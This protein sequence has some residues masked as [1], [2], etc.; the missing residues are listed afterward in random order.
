MIDSIIHILLG[1]SLIF[2]GIGGTYQ[3]KATNL[4]F[5]SHKKLE[6]KV[7]EIEKITDIIKDKLKYTEGHYGKD[8]WGS[9]E[10][11][12]PVLERWDQLLELLKVELKDAEPQ[13]L[14]KKK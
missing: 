13:H 7:F 14:I 8:D 11:I 9:I 5:K 1:A 2:I 4:L 6:D 10:Y 3:D 12:E